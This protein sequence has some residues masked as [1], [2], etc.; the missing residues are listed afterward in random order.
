MLQNS[1]RQVG[2][3]NRALGPDRLGRPL[4]ASRHMTNAAVQLRQTGHLCFAQRNRAGISPLPWDK[5]DG[6]DDMLQ[7]RTRRAFL[8]GCASGE[9]E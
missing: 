1:I 5:A 2:A 9:W 6:Q 8:A 4:A 3:P 7:N